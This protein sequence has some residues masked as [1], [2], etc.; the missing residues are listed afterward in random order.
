MNQ[1]LTDLVAEAVT[2]GD[3]TKFNI[4]TCRMRQAISE[5]KCNTGEILDAPRSVKK[6]ISRKDIAN[7]STLN[8]GMRAQ[9][10]KKKNGSARKKPKI[11]NS[12]YEDYTQPDLRLLLRAMNESA[13]GNNSDQIDRLMSRD[14]GRE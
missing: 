11:S 4:A 3:D 6:R 9:C 8:I 7:N 13:G 10:G 2:R 14:K 1:L 5:C 12:N